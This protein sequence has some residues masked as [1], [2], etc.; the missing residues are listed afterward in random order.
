MYEEKNNSKRRINLKLINMEK[1]TK[2]EEI[3][4]NLLKIKE[5]VSE[6]EIEARKN[7]DPKTSDLK[8][9]IFKSTVLKKEIERAQEVLDYAE[10]AYNKLLK[11]VE[12]YKIIL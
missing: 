2:M 8:M 9:I 7:K 5:K 3:I 12:E 4:N 6:K 11:Q 10:E 1:S